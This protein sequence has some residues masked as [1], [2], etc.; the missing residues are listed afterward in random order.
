[1][2]KLGPK[3]IVKYPFVEDAVSFI[4][5]NAFTLDV[6]GTSP[7]MHAFIDTAM[8]RIRTAADGGVYETPPDKFGKRRMIETLS[9]SV[10]VILLK[11]CGMQTLVRRFALAEARRAE[12]NL[13]ADLKIYSAEKFEIA[14]RL[15]GDLFSVNIQRV[16]DDIL[17][18]VQ[19]YL[20]RA[21][22]FHE[23]EWN[24]VNRRVSKGQVYLTRHE[25]VRVLRYLLYA[26]LHLC[27]L[28]QWFYMREPLYRLL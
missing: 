1:M 18:P 11:L 20:I 26:P 25:A 6:L 2:I 7:D 5:K 23:R 16:D 12:K 4:Q 27:S 8:K 19:D 14:K 3:E 10:A 9:F 24:L 21:A 22:N 17:V 15:I 13:E 28:F